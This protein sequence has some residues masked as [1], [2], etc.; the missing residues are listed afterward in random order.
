MHGYQVVSDGVADVLLGD[1]DFVGTNQLL[2][3]GILK[4]LLVSM[5]IQAKYYIRLDMD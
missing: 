4:I 3:L 1:K 5:M 2:E